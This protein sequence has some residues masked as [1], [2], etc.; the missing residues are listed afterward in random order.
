MPS[1]GM[2]ELNHKSTMACH[3]PNTHPL[4]ASTHPVGRAGHPSLHMFRGLPPH[5]NCPQ[6]TSL[7]SVDHLRHTWVQDDA[8]GPSLSCPVS[9]YRGSLGRASKNASF[10]PRPT[11]R[12]RL[13]R[14]QRDGGISETVPHDGA[15]LVRFLR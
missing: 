10:L 9:K 2:M 7:S 11:P 14:S 15:P 8:G 4:P 5:H 3:S 1:K 13:G 12:S 6:P